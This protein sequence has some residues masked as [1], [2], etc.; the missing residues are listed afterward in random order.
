[1][2]I[3]LVSREFAP[4]FGGGIGTYI[5]LASRAFAAAGHEV[6]VLTGPHPGLE[7]GHVLQDNVQVHVVDR[8]LG[9]GAL[10]AYRNDAMHYAMGVHETLLRLHEKHPFDFIEFPDYWGE[11]SFAI[12]AK[13]TLGHYQS[14]VL[15]VRLHTPTFECQQLNRIMALDINAASMEHQENSAMREADVI[16]SPTHSLLDMVKRR[17]E[18]PQHAEVLPHPFEVKEFAAASSV[19]PAETK[20][21]QV[22]YF[23]RLEYR[24]GI[25]VLIDA[26]LE[27]LK[28]QRN[29]EF[30]FIGGDTPTGPFGQSMLT[31]L[32]K[33]I[34]SE[35]RSH[36]VFEKS[37]PRAEL[38]QAIHSATVCCFPSIWEN[39]P[40]VCLEAMAA[41]AVVVGSD[42]GGMGEIIED[43]KNGLL[44]RA[45]QVDSLVS[46]LERALTDEPLRQ[47]LRAAAPQR[48]ATYCSPATYVERTEKVVKRLAP[49]TRREA[50]AAPRSKKAQA[51]SPAVSI[52]VPYYNMGRFLPET[53]VSLKQQT[54]DDYEIIIIDDGSTD[55]ASKALLDVLDG[56]KLHII[57]KPNGGLS[58]A[59]N[60]GLRKARGRWILPVDPDDLLA[61]TFLEKMVDVMSRDAKLAFATSMVAYFTEDP[62]K[63]I[64]GWTPWGVERDALWLENVASTCT[65]L[66]E[67]KLVEE[68]GGYDEWLSSFEDW[69]VF[70]SLA[71][72]GYEG[73]VIPEFLFHYRVRPDSLTRT[74]ATQSRH[75][76]RAYL[77]Q[78][79]PHLPKDPNRAMR[80]QLAETD[81]VQEM[82]KH[83][84][85]GAH[86]GLGDKPLRYQLVDFANNTVKRFGFIHSA[87]RR[88]AEAAVTTGSENGDSRSAS[89]TLTENILTKLGG[90]KRLNRLP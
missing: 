67:R 28:R 6:H 59:R 48:I 49:A 84:S 5:L 24:K 44:F 10:S 25:H 61:P 8:K 34:P 38:A 83:A 2:R 22:L 72:R 78:K 55:A 79:H 69:D 19:A 85:P 58:S 40:N 50:K 15:A 31:W 27:L 81:R 90:P 47:T 41:G 11:G 56:P 87:L 77:L 43:G 37:R 32:Q 1:M 16:L 60:A 73:T 30:R 63:P 42:A 68:V 62:Q 35:W 76:L 20:P 82:L 13:R 70:C 80:L 45:G 14:A 54:F 66:M 9:M 26:G 7:D 4:F 39:F 29:V 65:A 46:A 57:R 17:L 75:P 12:R 36:F 86:S 18:L 74:V 88:T 71:E 3:C 33:R 53:L 51:T 52:L 21:A 89:A 64:G 23:G